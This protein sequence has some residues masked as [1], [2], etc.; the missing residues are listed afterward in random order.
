M[1]AIRVLNYWCGYYIALLSQIK[2]LKENSFLYSPNL[3]YQTSYDDAYEYS[4]KY[5]FFW[6]IWNFLNVTIFIFLIIIIIRNFYKY[7]INS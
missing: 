5:K 3:E 4:V 2:M 6:S 1:R 7:T